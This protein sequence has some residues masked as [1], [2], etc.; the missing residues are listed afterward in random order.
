MNAFQCY[1]I[2]IICS[3][4][5]MYLTGSF[6]I[7]QN[8]RYVHDKS[9]ELPVKQI[10]KEIIELEEEYSTDTLYLCLSDTGIPLYF[11]RDI[12]TSVC[13]DNVCRPLDVKLLWN[14]TG[15]YLGF[16]LENDEF[17]SKYEHEPFTNEEYIK[18][19][20]ILS[21]P[22]LPL[23]NVSFNEVV[24]TSSNIAQ[25]IDGISGATSKDLS[26]YVVEG[27]AYT[28]HK[29]YKIIYGQTQ[30]I[31][32]ELTHQFKGPDFIN[33][34]MNSEN[35]YDKIWTMEFIRGQLKLYPEVKSQII[36][37]ISSDNYSL[38]EKAINVLIAEDFENEE[39]QVTV[40]GN[41]KKFDYGRRNW[42]I[43]LLK[44]TKTI[45]PETINYLNSEIF[46]MEIPLVVEIL[47]I[48]KKNKIK[49]ETSLQIATKLAE[50]TNAYLSGLANDYL[51]FVK[52]N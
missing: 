38:S 50:S 40:M 5:F 32:R 45:A 18:L 8:I 20:N 29:M 4:I 26:D 22:N 12:I 24:K 46:D 41:F 3:Y 10:Y 37:L 28:T 52:D 49:N 33:L 43:Q 17:L 30:D 15:R 14:P 47:K 39:L 23:G 19:H 51:V 1:Y 35:F 42:L 2:G 34:L 31:I 21:N 36:E 25:G 16:E 44:D 9:I 48:Y 6:P 27:A 13:F 11:Y 7:E